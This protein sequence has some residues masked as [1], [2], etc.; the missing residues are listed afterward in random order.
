ML[1]IVGDVALELLF[2]EGP[3]A[4]RCRRVFTP[5]VPVPE[6]AVD[7]NHCPV[8]RQYDIRFA[9]HG[10]DVFAEA[11]SRPV[12]QGADEDFRLGVFAPDSRHIPASPVWGEVVHGRRIARG[13]QKSKV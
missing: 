1:F 10:A 4:F 11:V 2:P 9:G 7:K 5:L 13:S 8:L 12:E 6:T 3:V